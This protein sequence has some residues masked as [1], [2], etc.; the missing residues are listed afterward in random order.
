MADV[1]TI[2]VA[3][4]WL[5]FARP[6]SDAEGADELVPRAAAMA[7]AARSVLGV[8]NVPEAHRAH[9]LVLVDPSGSMK[10]RSAI[11]GL[12]DVADGLTGIHSVLG[13]GGKRLEWFLATNPIRRFASAT[14]LIKDLEAEPFRLGTSLDVPEI[15]TSVGAEL[16]VV[17]LVSD[18]VPGRLAEFADVDGQARH[19]V[20]VANPAPVPPSVGPVE[21]TQWPSDAFDEL[22]L[23]ALARDLLRGCFAP[24]TAFGQSVGA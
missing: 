5:R 18:D 10:T 14:A 16:A 9:V 3:D 8:G 17:F 12:L 6:A 7:A 24:N 15:A 22:R 11:S 21:V 20:V 2:G 23:P 13:A 19:V 1:V 4:E